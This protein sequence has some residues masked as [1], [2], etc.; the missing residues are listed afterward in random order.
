M[1]LGRLSP[2]IITDGRL[3]ETIL[4]NLPI[5]FDLCGQVS[6]HHV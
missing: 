1:K 4:T 5:G 2:N 6:T 3:W